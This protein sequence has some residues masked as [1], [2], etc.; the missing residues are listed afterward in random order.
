VKPKLKLH[1]ITVLTDRGEILNIFDSDSRRIVEQRAWAAMRKGATV[2]WEDGRKEWIEERHRIDL[3]KTGS[4]MYTW[5]KKGDKVLADVF[6]VTAHPD[7]RR[8]EKRIGK[9]FVDF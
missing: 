4:A 7:G 2:R 6:L 9:K 1:V 8:T 3:T 5:D